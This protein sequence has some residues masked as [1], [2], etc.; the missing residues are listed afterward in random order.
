M[1]ARIIGILRLF[2]GDS[3]MLGESKAINMDGNRVETWLGARRSR[4]LKRELREGAT[5]CRQAESTLLGLRSQGLHGVKESS[6]PQ[7]GLF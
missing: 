2:A 3:T 4:F 6:E 1:V 7:I 5:V